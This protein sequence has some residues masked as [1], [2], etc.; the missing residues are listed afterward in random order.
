VLVVDDVRTTGSTMR[1]AG[2]ALVAQG[3]R[4]LVMACLAVSD[5]PAR[6]SLRYRDSG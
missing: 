2:A 1:D 3:A 5:P 6:A 4:E